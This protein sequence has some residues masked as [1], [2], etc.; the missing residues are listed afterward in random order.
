LGTKITQER[1]EI[2]LKDRGRAEKAVEIIDLIDDITGEAC[3]TR[4]EILIPIV[5]IQMK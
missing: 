4:V 2:L 5:E 3:G 1:L